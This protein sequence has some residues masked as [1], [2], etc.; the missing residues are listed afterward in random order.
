[1]KLLVITVVMLLLPSILVAGGPDLTASAHKPVAHDFY[2]CLLELDVKKHEEKGMA[3][4]ELA[5][6]FFTDDVE[7]ALSMQQRS[8]F[9]IDKAS[10]QQLSDALS[11]YLHAHFE[12]FLG[13]DPGRLS[14]VEFSCLGFEKEHH[15]MWTFF[16]AEHPA[17]PYLSIYCDLLTEAFPTQENIVLLRAGDFAKRW[18]LHKQS[19]ELDINLLMH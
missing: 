3:S 1:M 4:L 17:G 5:V 11:N 14:R 16:E 13:T 7:M 8:P 6:R 18:T 12:L 10:Q 9:S 2:I 15:E 19:T